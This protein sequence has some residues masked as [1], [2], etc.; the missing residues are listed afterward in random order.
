MARAPRPHYEGEPTLAQVMRR[1][2]WIAALVLAL[3]VAGGFAWLGRWQLGHAVTLEHDDSVHSETARPISGVTGPGES[4]TDRAAGMVVTLDGSLVPGDFRVVEQRTN[5]G[6][7]GSWVTAHLVVSADVDS[8]DVDSTGVDSTDADDAS[9]I[10][11]LAVAI[12]WAPTTADAERAIAGLEA[13]PAL[14]SAVLPVEGRYMPSD[15]TVVPEPSEDPLVV[16][17]MAPAQ[18]VNL[19]APFE[20]L[21][22]SG[23]L[24]LH[25]SPDDG[26]DPL[27]A[28]A[29]AEHGLEAIDSVPPLPAETINWLNLFY[30]VEWVVF[31]GFAVYMWYRLTRDDWEKQHELKQLA[32]SAAEGEGE[33]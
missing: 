26:S 5:G 23:F 30:A 18:I 4:V 10:G 27:W 13:D 24:V 15:A 2:R 32:E 14:V 17:T 20:G 11:H 22:Y 21:A 29:L 33:A 7:I 25:G 3:A 12:G 6:R 28:A 31:A 19:W 9:A 1:P 8:A 16:T